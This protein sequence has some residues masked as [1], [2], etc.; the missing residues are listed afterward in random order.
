MTADLSA[1]YRHMPKR[2][3]A[4]APVALPGGLLKF[5]EIAPAD[6]PVPPEVATAARAAVAGIA[7]GLRGDDLGFVILHRCGASFYFLLVSVWRG[8]NELWEAV[9]YLTPAGFAPFDPAYPPAGAARPTFCVWELGVVAFEAQAWSAF[10]RSPR[11]AA[12]VTGWRNALLEG[13]V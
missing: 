11:G 8:A 5:Y 3:R 6:M 2:A 4:A 10:L 12:D 9:W 13:D 7:E 1:D